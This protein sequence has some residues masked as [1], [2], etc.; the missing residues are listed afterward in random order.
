VCVCVCVDVCAC[1]YVHTF[2]HSCCNFAVHCPTLSADLAIQLAEPY[3]AISWP[4]S[5]AAMR[6]SQCLQQYVHYSVCKLRA[7]QLQQ[8]LWSHTQEQQLPSCT[9][10]SMGPNK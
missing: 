9:L 10:H 6:E 8:L 4:I 2:V 1:L 7:F 3:F 5:A